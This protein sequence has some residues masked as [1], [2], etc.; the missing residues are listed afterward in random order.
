MGDGIQLALEQQLFSWLP[1]R[2]YR[3]KRRE[4]K[5]HGRTKF[6]SSTTSILLCR[7]PA[8]LKSVWY[9]PASCWGHASTRS[10]RRPK[11][12]GHASMRNSRG[13]KRKPIRWA[14]QHSWF[15]YKAYRMFKL[16][17]NS[18]PGSL[19]K[20]LAKIQGLERACD[21]VSLKWLLALL[22]LLNGLICYRKI[23]R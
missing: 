11:H 12:W 19:T 22:L 20:L 21:A 6:E 17:G 10:S 23:K 13:P 4:V 1:Q 14:F 9:L 16:Q 7:H 3:L 15:F 18:V 8:N 2:K 5:F